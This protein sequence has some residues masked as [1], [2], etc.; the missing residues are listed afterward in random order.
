MLGHGDYLQERQRA[1]N[2]KPATTDGA[3]RPHPPPRGYRTTSYLSDSLLAGLAV[4]HTGCGHLNGA[5]GRLLH[6]APLGERQP[7]GPGLGAL[8]GDWRRARGLFWDVNEWGRHHHPGCGRGGDAL[9]CLHRGVKRGRHLLLSQVRSSSVSIS[10][11][12]AVLLLLVSGA[13][14]AELQRPLFPLGHQLP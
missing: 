6:C 1:Q 11:F 3:K 8:G 2:S 10:L 13:L 5:F 12:R 7:L 9:V 4:G 14:A